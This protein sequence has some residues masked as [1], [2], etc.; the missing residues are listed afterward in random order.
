MFDEDEVDKLLDAQRTP[1]SLQEPSCKNMMPEKDTV[2]SD[3]VADVNV[4]G[5]KF[6]EA[7]NNQ[8][9][10]LDSLGKIL[11]NDEAINIFRLCR[12]VK[13]KYHSSPTP[14]N[15]PEVYVSNANPITLCVGVPPTSPCPLDK[16]S[17]LRKT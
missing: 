2:Q 10:N 7:I 13:S 12:M 8:Q 16:Y 4:A 9:V 3:L 15:K 6:L 5:A 17:K 14:N 11:Q 1:R